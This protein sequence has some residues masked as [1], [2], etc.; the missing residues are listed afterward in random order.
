MKHI[1]NIN[2]SFGRSYDFED[3]IDKSEFI[4]IK[5]SPWDDLDVDHVDVSWSLRLVTNKYGV[6]GLYVS[7][8]RVLLNSYIEG[9]A[10]DIEIDNLEWSPYIEIKKLDVRDSFYVR[11]I[12]VDMKG[13]EDQRDWEVEV[14]FGNEIKNKDE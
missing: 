4:L 2:E 7:V 14:S 9:G 12:Q 6:E 10:S 3:S 5:G 11:T 13:T 1:K 8:N